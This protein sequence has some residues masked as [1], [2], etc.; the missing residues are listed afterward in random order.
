VP[1]S[2]SAF[3]IASGTF[4]VDCAIS[5]RYVDLFYILSLYS[6]S[7]YVS[8]SPLVILVVDGAPGGSHAIFHASKCFVWPGIDGGRQ[9]STVIVE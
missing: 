3:I 1:G 6:W 2:I 7:Y 5:Y 4:V 9:E 8:G